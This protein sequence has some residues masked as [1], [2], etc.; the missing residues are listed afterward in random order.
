MKSVTEWVTTQ[1]RHRG[2]GKHRTTFKSHVIEVI[3]TYII[4]WM[5]ACLIATVKIIHTVDLDNNEDKEH[6]NKLQ[7]Y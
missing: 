2:S 1:G 7:H 3:S 5:H 4:N 6:Q